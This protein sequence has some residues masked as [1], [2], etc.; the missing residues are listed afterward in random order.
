MTEKH[1][2]PET[3]SEN[4]PSSG[5]R[6]PPK[7]FLDFSE[8]EDLAQKM[9]QVRCKLLVLSGKGGVGKSTIAANLAISLARAGKEVGL[10]DADIHGPSLPRLLNL[11]G[12]RLITKGEMILPLEVMKHLKVMSIG[13][14][15]HEGDEAVIWRGP[16]KMSVIKQFLK[17]VHWSTLD[18]LVVDS[19]PGTGD[20]PLTISQLLGPGQAA[21]IV[22]TPQ[23]IALIDV[24]KCISFCRKLKL[25]ILGVIENMSGFVCP[26]CGKTTDIFKSGGGEKLAQE[27]GVAFLGRIPIDPGV[28]LA[29]DAGE[30]YLQEYAG[31]PTAW[32]FEQ[33][34]QQILDQEK[35]A[36]KE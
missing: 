6:S 24:R 29:S 8:R 26:H 36:G 3:P 20:E 9:A 5:D 11:E 12:R 21:V 25:P 13:F 2:K 10:L 4:S 22:T 16:L 23:D 34:V 17:D 15:L 35:S 30:S 28:V 19:P 33:V 1:S 31:T 14:F 18:Y 27:M 7:M 32:A